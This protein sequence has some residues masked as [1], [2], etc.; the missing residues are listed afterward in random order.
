MKRYKEYAHHFPVILKSMER[1]SNLFILTTE[2]NYGD[3]LSLELGLFCNGIV[4]VRTSKEQFA[5]PDYPIV[6]DDIMRLD[7]IEVSET[8]EKY[9][10]AADRFVIEICKNPYT[11]KIYHND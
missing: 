9:R 10:I 5:A 6:R 8:G 4:R 1:K 2:D 3:I 7:D 11:F